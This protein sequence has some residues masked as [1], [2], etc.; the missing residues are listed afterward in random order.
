MSGDIIPQIIEDK[1]KGTM[2]I[3]KIKGTCLLTNFEPRNVKDALENESW[4]KAM[5]EERENREEENLDTCIEA[6]R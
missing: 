6:K 1:S 3:S 2:T 4:I 5:N